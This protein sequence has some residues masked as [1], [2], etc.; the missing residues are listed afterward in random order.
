MTTYNVHI[1]REMRITFGSIEADTPD[2]AAA[3]AHTKPTGDADDIDD[4]DG[5]DFAALVDVAGDEEYEQSRVIDFEP[6]RHR[7]LAPKLLASL[8]AI[9]PYAENEAYSLEKH[10]DSPEAETEA[11]RAWE[12]IDSARAAIAEA[13]AAGITPAP[14]ELDIHA[15]LASRRQIAAIWSIEDV[16][17]VRPDL[18]DEQAWE[19]LQQ[20]KRRHDAEIGIN[21]IV[22]ECHADMLH[23]DAPDA[24]EPEEA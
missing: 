20:V 13:K 23:D 12:A 8:E 2:A 17:Q 14:A 1:Y 5:E 10:K 3:M 15:L 6:E 16:Q 7:K 24:D 18:T 4:C 19:V 21:W 11:D 22:L 9:L